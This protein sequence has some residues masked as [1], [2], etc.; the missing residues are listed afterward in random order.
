MKKSH[1]A[2]SYLA[3]N[4][5]LMALYGGQPEWAHH[6][7][8]TRSESNQESCCSCMPNSHS[9]GAV[10]CECPYFCLCLKPVRL[11]E[12]SVRLTPTTNWTPTR[13]SC[14]CIT[15]G[16][17]LP[18]YPGF[19]QAKLDCYAQLHTSLL[20]EKLIYSYRF[21]KRLWTS[22]KCYLLLQQ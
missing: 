18:I 6:P 14:E 21:N 11:T 12:T 13:L 16:V 19:G 2:T 10:E 7:L 9:R 8:M 4:N 20:T 1:S 5:Q 3:D 22:L 15:P 17:T